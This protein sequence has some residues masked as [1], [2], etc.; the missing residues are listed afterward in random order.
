VDRRCPEAAAFFVVRPVVL[1]EAFEARLARV[2]VEPALLDEE[3]RGVDA[4]FDREF[5]DDSEIDSKV[6]GDL[7]PTFT[8]TQFTHLDI[9][10]RIV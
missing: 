2:F 5:R 3:L 1:P 4:I 7:A 6:V 10:R 9:V 8:R